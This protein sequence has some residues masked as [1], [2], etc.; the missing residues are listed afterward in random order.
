MFQ[1]IL[2]ADLATSQQNLIDFAREAEE[3]GF[4]QYAE[5]AIFSH[6]LLERVMIQTRVQALSGKC[7]SCGQEACDICSCEIFPSRIP[8]DEE[9]KNRSRMERFLEWCDYDAAWEYVQGDARKALLEIRDNWKAPESWSIDY[10]ITPL[11]PSIIRCQ[12]LLPIDSPYKKISLPPFPRRNYEVRR[13]L[14]TAAALTHM[15]GGY[16]LDMTDLIPFYPKVWTKLEPNPLAS[17]ATF[18]G[19]I[20]YPAP[21]NRALEMAER[22]RLNKLK[23]EGKREELGTWY[24]WKDGTKKRDPYLQQMLEIAGAKSEA[25]LF[26]SHPSFLVSAADGGRKRK[27]DDLEMEQQIHVSPLPISTPPVPHSVEPFTPLS[28]TTPPVSHSVEPPIVPLSTPPAITTL[29]TPPNI[30]PSINPPFTPESIPPPHNI[31]PSIN[32]P[33][34]PQ[35]ITIPPEDHKVPDNIIDSV[36]TLE[37]LE[38]QRACRQKHDELFRNFMKSRYHE[39]I[40]IDLS[41]KNAWII[42]QKLAEIVVRNHK[43]P[44]IELKYL[45]ANA[46]HG[47]TINNKC[48]YCWSPLLG[49]HTAQCGATNCIKF[50]SSAET[51]RKR[52]LFLYGGATKAIKK[53]IQSA[54]EKIKMSR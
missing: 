30:E 28:V 53:A 5:S 27:Y 35:S 22:R 10:D 43:N 16:H 14:G 37:P 19:V 12:S 48:R 7:P 23:P 9:A 13:R 6:D 20:S 39:D 45:F 1:S 49:S 32:P 47:T 21:T 25:E 3:A 52:A 18:N 26:G 24:E 36:W 11:F 2:T 8:I 29:P 50:H 54:H 46:T 34:T 51:A 17:L 40:D 41:E 44:D 15:L 31:E 42:L 38:L 33:F 4:T